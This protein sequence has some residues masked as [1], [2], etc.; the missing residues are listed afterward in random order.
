VEGALGVVLVG[1]RSS[2]G[3]HDCVAGE[4]LHRAPRRSDLRRHGVV[5][6]VEKRAGP[7]RILLAER[8]R[9]DEVG[10]QDGGDFALGRSFGPHAAILPRP[11]PAGKKR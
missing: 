5:E 11:G 1:G 4:L 6:A 2:E 9:P 3:R 8:R 10:E 7:L